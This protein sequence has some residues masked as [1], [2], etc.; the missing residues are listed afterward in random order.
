[1]ALLKKTATGHDDAKIQ[2]QQKYFGFTDPNIPVFSFVGR[3][4][5]QKGVH[6]ILNS[7]GELINYSNGKIQI[8]VSYQEDSLSNLMQ[9]CADRRNGKYE[10]SIC[11]S[12]CM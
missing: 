2:L 3:I 6:L 4:V 8:I 12:M 10:R 11:S 7:V 1:M 9:N 5:L